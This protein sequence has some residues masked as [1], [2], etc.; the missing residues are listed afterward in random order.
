MA[1]A[2]V[3]AEASGVPVF[4]TMTGNTISGDS[5]LTLARGCVAT[6]AGKLVVCTA[7]RKAGLRIVIEL[8]RVPVRRI[9]ASVALA[10]ECAAMRVIVRVAGNT[11]GTCVVKCRRRMAPITRDFGVRTQQRKTGQV[12]VEKYPRHPVGRDV[13]AFALRA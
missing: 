12:V 1:T 11:I 5:Q 8:P 7:Q 3:L 9:V 10:G 6:G 13:T 2:A 4:T